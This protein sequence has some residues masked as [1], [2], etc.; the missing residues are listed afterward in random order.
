M[1]KL[2]R[3]NSAVYRLRMAFKAIRE[4]LLI[5]LSFTLILLFL[6]SVGIYY[7]E[8]AEQPEMFSSIFESMWFAVVSLTTVGYGDITPVTIGGRVFTSFILFLGLGIVA[9]PT[10]LFAAALT[11]QKSIKKMEEKE[12][13]TD[14]E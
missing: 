2:L 3:Y 10:G 4:E 5:F 7:F 1:A 12:K 13:K 9:V 8:H 6:S 11:R 14:S